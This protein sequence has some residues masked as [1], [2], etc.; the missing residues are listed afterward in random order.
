MNDKLA[1]GERLFNAGRFFE[2][3]EAFEDAWRAASGEPKV[4]AQGL[5]QLA[6][7]FVR[8][9]R[10][11]GR[12]PGALYLLR[13]AREKLAA[14]PGLV[15]AVEAAAAALEAGRPAAPPR[16]ELARDAR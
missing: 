11:G 4:F 2:A 5:A 14:L 10:Q 9:E 8:L 1:E 12:S 13:K 3:H 16:L 6:A 15:S 7:A